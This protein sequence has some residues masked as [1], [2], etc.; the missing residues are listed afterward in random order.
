MAKI[1]KLIAKYPIIAVVA[2]AAAS[3]YLGPS[4]AAMLSNIAKAIGLSN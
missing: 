1:R 3:A 4:G 2:T